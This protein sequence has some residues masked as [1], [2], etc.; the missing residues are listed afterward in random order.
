MSNCL[1][2]GDRCAIEQLLQEK[3]NSLSSMSARSFQCLGG[4]GPIMDDLE[5]EAS[6]APLPTQQGSVGG[7]HLHSGLTQGQKL[8]EALWPQDECG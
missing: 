8:A 6:E 4:L 2:L 5:I 1:R 7:P 3:I